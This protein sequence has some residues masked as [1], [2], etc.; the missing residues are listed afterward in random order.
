[1]VP[2]AR[3]PRNPC[4]IVFS[5]WLNLLNAIDTE[6]LQVFDSR[7]GYTL[8]EIRRGIYRNPLTDTSKSRSP[9]RS[10]KRDPNIIKYIVEWGNNREAGENTKYSGAKAKQ[11]VKHHLILDWRRRDLSEDGK[12]IARP[13]QSLLWCC[14]VESWGSVPF[15][16]APSLRYL[17]HAAAFQ[18]PCPLSA[19]TTQRNNS[20]LP[21]LR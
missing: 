9:K 17:S 7:W 10:A 11:P 12:R 3:V 6:G 8:L 4:W 5:V 1:M 13:C 19:S 21:R 20:S 16:K 2:K 18:N 14:G 15:F